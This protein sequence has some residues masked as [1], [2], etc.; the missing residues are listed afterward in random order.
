VIL[1]TGT[2]VGYFSGN[3][4]GIP[5]G[6]ANHYQRDEVNWYD[7]QYYEVWLGN[8]AG[9][10]LVPLRVYRIYVDK[11]VETID[12]KEVYW[13]EPAGGY[14]SIKMRSRI[15]FSIDR[16]STRFESYTD[17]RADINRRFRDGGLKVGRLDSFERMEFSKEVKSGSYKLRRYYQGILASKVVWMRMRDRQGV[18][19]A[20]KMIV[21]DGSTIL[22]D[23]G[24]KVTIKFVARVFKNL[25]VL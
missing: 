23:N 9:P 18:L 25:E 19:R 24:R 14:A 15:V 22:V 13:L 7:V 16:V 4:V 17:L 1:H 12:E 6:P 21:E 11:C 2:P 3:A 5:I 20:V 10:T 8:F